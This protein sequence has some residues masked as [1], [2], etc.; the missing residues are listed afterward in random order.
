MK[1]KTIN[2]VEYR[3]KYYETNKDRLTSEIQCEC[4]KGFYNLATKT[5]HLKSKRHLKCENLQNNTI[6]I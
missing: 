2:M 3:K 1:T 6:A 4:C 5:R